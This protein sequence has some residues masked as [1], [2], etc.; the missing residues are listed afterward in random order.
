GGNLTY[1]LATHF[2][3]SEFSCDA[4]PHGRDV[5]LPTG[6]NVNRRRNAQCEHHC[7]F[8]P[9]PG[10]HRS[11]RHVSPMRTGT[12]TWMLRSAL[13]T[14]SKKTLQCSRVL[15]VGWQQFRREVS[16]TFQTNIG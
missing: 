7:P 13:R 16:A 11:F 9:R 6:S 10:S 8:G 1:R 3:H 4:T 15:P 5:L 2:V 14:T 12:L